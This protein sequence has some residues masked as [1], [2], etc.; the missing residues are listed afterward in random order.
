MVTHASVL[1]F[2]FNATPVIHGSPPT[3]LAR[4]KAG[5][6]VGGD[7]LIWLQVGALSVELVLRKTDP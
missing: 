3:W 6:P 2:G 5:T 4:V 1:L 7:P